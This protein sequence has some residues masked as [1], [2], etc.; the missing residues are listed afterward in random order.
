MQ[1]VV[2]KLEGKEIFNNYRAHNSK[3]VSPEASVW[4]FITLPENSAGKTVRFEWESSIKAFSGLI[5]PIYYGSGDALLYDILKTYKW[6]IFVGILLILIG[7]ITT[8]IS[9]F[10]VSIKDNRAVFLGLF[11]MMVGVW[12]LSE[13]RVMQFLTGHRFLIGGASYMMLSL[14]PIPFLLYIRETLLKKYHKWF[15][16]PAFAFLGTF[17]LNLTLQLTGICP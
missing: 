11:S 2:V 14:F 10:I 17:L 4:Y 16:I 1:Q 6:G 7:G 5:N 8:K 13:A 3:I 9:Y 15:Y 12:V